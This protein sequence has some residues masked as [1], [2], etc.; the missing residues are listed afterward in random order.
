MTAQKVLKENMEDSAHDHQE[1][2]YYDKLWSGSW[3]LTTRIG[4]SCRT[5][6]RL[7]LQLL[8]KY[9]LRNDMDIID[10]G[11]GDGT[12]LNM[13]SLKGYSS[14]YGFEFSE[15]GVRKSQ[16]QLPTAK[17]LFVGDL[18]K[19][20]TLPSEAFDVVI[21]SEVLEHIEDYKTA[22]KNLCSFVKPGGRLFVTVPHSMKYWTIHDEFAHHCRRYEKGELEGLISTEGCTIVESFSWGA[23]LYHLYYFFLKQGDPEKIMGNKSRL[24]K[25]LAGQKQI[26]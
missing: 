5:R 9:Y 2:A 14:L 20:E 6:F 16:E 3:E 13:L 23:F 21:S 17:K 25:V 8:Q 18:T 19:K 12:L 10:T 22:V 15:E 1:K 11:C 24:K 4:P 7:L 26:D